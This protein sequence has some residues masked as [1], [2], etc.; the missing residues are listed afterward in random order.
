MRRGDLIALMHEHGMV[1]P[2]ARPE[3]LRVAVIDDDPLLVRSS[4]RALR[5]AFPAAQLGTALNGF[6]AGVL[7]AELR[8]H[9]VLL[10]VVMPGLSGV[11]VCSQIRSTPSLVDTRVIIVSGHVDRKLQAELV[12]VGADHFVHKPFTGAVLVAAV[13]AVL[14]EALLA[15]RA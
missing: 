3:A 8:P 10:D 5:R 14:P 15:E 4:S 12:A 9:V 13:R 2:G 7:M 6:A 11:E 1:P